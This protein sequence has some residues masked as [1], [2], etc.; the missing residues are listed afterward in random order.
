MQK[1]FAYP[2]ESLFLCHVLKSKI[3]PISTSTRTSW[4]GTSRFVFVLFNCPRR[5][6]ALHSG[7]SQQ[8]IESPTPFSYW[9]NRISGHQTLPEPFYLLCASSRPVYER[10]IEKNGRRIRPLYAHIRPMNYSWNASEKNLYHYCYCCDDVCWYEIILLSPRFRRKCD[11]SSRP[12]ENVWRLYD[13][14]HKIYDSISYD[15]QI[16]IY[17]VYIKCFILTTT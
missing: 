5:A 8:C 1:W 11:C 17:Y 15:C 9:N 16:L 12:L 13:F 2:V 3:N 6:F 14:T 7:K 4:V 10:P